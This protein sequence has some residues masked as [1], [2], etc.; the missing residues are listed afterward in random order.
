MAADRLEVA[1]LTP[2]YHP[3]TGGAETYTRHAL[4]AL[5]RRGHRV[6]VV[7][8]T[9]GA[10]GVDVVDGV[11]VHR[12]GPPRI[13][14]LAGSARWLPRWSRACWRVLDDVAPSVLFAHYTGIHAAARWARRNPT[15]V[16]ALVHDVYGFVENVRWRGPVGGTVRYLNNDRLLVR[17]RPDVVVAVSEATAAAAR[18]R[19]R[20]PISVARPGCDHVP[21]GPDPDPSSRRVLFVGRLVRSKGLDDALASV[22][23]A[24]ASV[25]DAT[26]VVV[27]SGPTELALPPW[28]TRL[29]AIDDDEL[30]REFR[31]SA[32]LVL[33]SQREG[34]GLV[35][36][37]AA[38]R[39]LPYVAY[40]IPALR[41]QHV[42]VGGGVLTPPGDVDALARS[43]RAL[44]TDSQLR[45]RLGARGHDSAR[46]YLTWRQ[47]AEVVESALFAA[48]DRSAGSRS[49]DAA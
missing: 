42:L 35:V 37:E 46:R 34:W 27:G 9:T 11:T 45:R 28:V 40:D 47:T 18:V 1:F 31:S 49:V 25:P 21:P 6:T 20:A 33:P 36:T 32:A 8:G 7:S 19:T 48:R 22:A 24:R 10:T 43:V 3:Q 23:A 13:G 5:A 38:A 29:G 2:A 17:A 12:V 14:G 4:A 41:E 30:D 26:L 39:G 16:V 15:P 44:L